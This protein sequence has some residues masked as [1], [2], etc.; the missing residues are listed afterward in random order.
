MN[1]NTTKIVSYLYSHGSMSGN[2]I[3]R[4]CGVTEADVD[5]AAQEGD[6]RRCT[7]AYGGVHPWFCVA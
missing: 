4:D 1:I 2:D 6:I 5:F 3:M 7:P